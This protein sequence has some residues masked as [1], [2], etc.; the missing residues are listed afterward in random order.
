MRRNLDERAQRKAFDGVFA[1]FDHNQ[2]GKLFLK[3][4]YDELKNH[5]IELD[6]A[7]KKKIEALADIHGQVSKHDFQKYSKSSALFQSLD[8]N[9]DGI[10]NVTEMTSKAEMA[11]KALDKNNDGYLSKNE[12][13]K[14]LK[15]LSKEQAAK[16]MEKF[17]KDGDGKL[18]FE[19]FQK[20]LRK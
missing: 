3:D 20:M 7:E 4:Y 19:E 13:N 2:N 10:V 9:K 15:N 8:Q 6:E 5:D 1:K 14:L 17:D 16:V 18:D 11:F 12:F